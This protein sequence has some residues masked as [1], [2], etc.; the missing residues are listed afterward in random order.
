M[1]NKT[2][3]IVALSLTAA[4][5]FSVGIPAFVRVFADENSGDFGKNYYIS[6]YES[7]SELS[8]AA[9]SLSD[10]I[11][12]E[13]VILLK[14][15]DN[16]L[17]IKEGEKISIL[18]KNSK[19][20]GY[21]GDFMAAGYE[22]NQTLRDFYNNNALS[23]PGADTKGYGNVISSGYATGETPISSYTQ[24]VKDSLAQYSDVG[25]VVF[26]RQTG[27]GMDAPRTMMW[28]GESQSVWTED[29]TELIPG[30]RAKDDHYLQLDQNE[31]DLLELC[32]KTF[33]K[34]IVLLQTPS[35]FE[36][37]FL[38]DPG[39]Y[40]YQENIKAGMFLSNNVKSSTPIAKILMGQISPSGH[41][42]DTW[43]RDFKLDPTWQ[44]FG[45]YLMEAGPANKGN[46]Y[47]NL[48]GTDGVGGGG[49]VNNYITYNEGIYV[50]YRYWE[51]RGYTEGN[52]SY[53]SAT[54]DERTSVID[55]KSGGSAGKSK[56]YVHGTTTTSWDSWYDAHVVYP[57]GHGLSYTTFEQTIIS[58]Q[59]SGSSKLT[60]DGTI[61]LNVKVKNTG[62]VAGK[63]V[64]QVYYTSPYKA[65]EIEKA[66]VALA[67]FEKTKLL[68]PQ[69]EQTLAVT[70]KV[71]DMASYDYSDANNNGFKGYELDAGDYVVKL[72]KNAHETIE[73]VTYVLENGIRY[74]TDEVTEGKVENRFDDVSNYIT[75]ELGQKYL[76]RNDWTGTW[77]VFNKRLTAS[78]NVIN[79]LKE[80]WVANGRQTR[81]PNADAQEP[82]YATEM[83]T[84][85]EDNGIV[86]EDLHGKAYDDPMWEEYLNEFT[87][88]QYKELVTR[89][90]YSSGKDYTELGVKEMDNCDGPTWLGPTG[91]AADPH[92][93]YPSVI[94][95]ASSWNK[96]LAYRF[97]KMMGED[98]LWAWND[99]IGGWYA[100]AINLHR[101]QFC[102]RNH[103]YYSEDG[104]L[105]GWMSGMEIKGAQ[106]KGLL[107]YVKHFA[108]N[109][110]ESNR[111]GLITWANEQSMRELYFVP[112]EICVK[113][114][115]ALG[116]MSSLNRIG[117]TWTG[118]SHELLTEVLRDEWGFHGCVVT[119]SFLGDISN[120]SNA[121][122]MIRAGGNLSLG[123]STLLYNP[124][125][126]TTY[127]C[128]REAAH[129]ILY[130]QAHSHAL[131]AL[132]QGE[133]YPVQIYPG[134]VL[135]R[136]TVG[137]PYS[138]NLANAKLSDVLFP[139]IDD[140]EIVYTVNAESKLPAGLTLSEQGLLSGTPTESCN[141]YRF[142]IDATYANYTRTA[143]FTISIV[144]TN[145][146][147]V[148]EADENLGTILVNKAANLSVAG[149]TVVK[150]NVAEGEALPTC[151]YALASGSKLPAGLTLNADGTITG[152]PTSVCENY[153]FSVTA[154]ASGYPSVTL[155]F[156]LNVFYEMT[157]TGGALA[158][159]KLGVSYMQKLP[160]AE[161]QGKVTY[162]LSEES[163]LP[164]GLTLTSGGY[165]TGTP[166]EAV[167]DHTFTVIATSPFTEPVEAQFTLTIGLSFN[168][169]TLQNG[170]TGES[171]SARVDTAQGAG[172][173]SYTLKEGSALPEG[174]TLSENGVISGTP[175]KAGDYTFTVVASAEGKVGDEITL[176]LHIDEGQAGG[177]SG[178]C[179]G[180]IGLGGAGVFLATVC[181]LGGVL[182]MRGKRKKE[183]TS[184]VDNEEK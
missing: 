21:V 123:N 81:D 169:T 138:Q 179:G 170:R 37:G 115:G 17:P 27:E 145:G 41:T 6:D 181:V 43:A 108:I 111:C 77:P 35:S 125:T 95:R 182:L 168:E 92:Y 165:I 52:S 34:V 151:T 184:R 176:T 142:K 82:Y 64:V 69:E 141:N 131:N 94:L 156:K 65:G 180:V 46:Q 22:V 172:E 174:L 118:G 14:N 67:A 5:S 146:A 144:G 112:F 155:P 49:Y 137:I 24:E 89:G 86:L 98:T 42:T 12:S 99:Q 139:D 78:E 130:A 79:G 84:T 120:L 102:G 16:A 162:A 53:M 100:P 178:G 13:G 149:A 1:K 148:Y 20:F 157:F 15:E 158:G 51:T 97:G 55:P 30:A 83:P 44:N 88:E 93:S 26:Y 103:E 90:H 104:V 105:A 153:A 163:K 61:T 91:G 3:T 124:D 128:L 129:G 106:E 175:S 132:P 48:P 63:D 74:E 62:T 107:V 80:W 119:D 154:S 152:T 161:T 136:G 4:M 109:N 50:G 147:I 114:G 76:S 60:A 117:T 38:D 29:S 7:R 9:G 167:T 71:R 150:S 122:Q 113:E 73:T 40:A 18:G 11:A 173:I 85:G 56:D 57:F 166:R 58:A 87:L 101:S 70:F 135:E 75:E 140:S 171:Y 36:S 45:N 116:V 31:A 59:P 110:S 32:G 47:E 159:G 160:A 8:K 133:H 54:E 177:N 96:D 72:M 126:P 134:A 33:K 183:D 25:I 164:N 10:E 28:N 2:R 19:M 23:G 143:E 39:H 127:A 121:D 66:H 68:Q